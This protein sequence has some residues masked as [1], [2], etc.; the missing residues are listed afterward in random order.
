M[1]EALSPC[2]AAQELYYLM[3]RFRVLIDF[4]KWNI[5]PYY[6][7][8]QP[9]IWLSGWAVA[10]VAMLGVM[11]WLTEGAWFEFVIVILLVRQHASNTNMR[12]SKAE[13]A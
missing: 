10:Y 1:T 12:R 2:T 13:H 9:T 8:G 3:M 6:R 4:N 7:M 11:L 5:L